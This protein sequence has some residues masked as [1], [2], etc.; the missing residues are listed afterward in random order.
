[1]SFELPPKRE[2]TAAKLRELEASAPNPV[3]KAIKAAMIHAAEELES[4]RNLADDVAAQLEEITRVRVSAMASAA[5]VD[6]AQRTF[7]RQLEE[8]A[9]RLRVM[10]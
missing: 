1:M 4:W 2:D 8:C 10:P 6:E 5:A 9:R 3:P 7:K